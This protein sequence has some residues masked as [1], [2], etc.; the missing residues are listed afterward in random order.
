MSKTE[1][2]ILRTLA[3]FDIFSRPLTLEEIA[4]FLYRLKASRLQILMGLEK[5]KKKKLIIQKEKYFVLF[6]GR[7]SIASFKKN[8]AMRR[9]RWQK[10][11]WVKK[12]LKYVPFVRNISVVNSLSF[13]ASTEDSDIDIMIVAAK[14]RLWTTRALVILVLEILGQNKNK[15]YKAGK[16]CLGFAFDETRLSLESL[17]LKNDIYLSYWL[18]RLEPVFGRRL[19]NELIKQNSWIFKELPNWQA[20]EPTKENFKK[21][22]L[23]KL[24]SGGIGDRLEKI[25]SN[26][27]I[28]RIWAD[29]ENLRNGSSVIADNHMM[30]LHAYDKRN[31]YYKEWKGLTEGLMFRQAQHQP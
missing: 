18:A 5:L 11:D 22:F 14:N 26:I 12:I 7:K 3:F 31:K 8:R 17:R 4:C 13:D 25:L 2:A 20:K 10:V 23:E 28:K 21:S 27:Q 29:P 30:K 9:S 24:L 15:W 6:S 16:F 1:K 19:Y